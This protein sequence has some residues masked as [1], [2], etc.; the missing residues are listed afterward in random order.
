MTYVLLGDSPDSLQLPSTRLYDLYSGMPVKC[1]PALRM[2]RDL[3]RPSD[4]PLLFPEPPAFALSKTSSDTATEQGGLVD[5]F[6]QET[7]ER[8][9]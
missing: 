8:C 5:H 6:A 7:G 3:S 4:M 1:F 2:L 9:A